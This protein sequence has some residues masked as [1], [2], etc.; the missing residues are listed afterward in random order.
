MKRI[1]LIGI[2]IFMSA[3]QMVSAIGVG[4]YKN[5]SC[6]LVD[7]IRINFKFRKEGKKFIELKDECQ[8]KNFEKNNGIDP[9]K[10][11]YSAYETYKRMLDQEIYF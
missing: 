9:I 11:G 7:G 3:S 8:D 1:V 2:I 4:Q 10:E 5:T 6:G